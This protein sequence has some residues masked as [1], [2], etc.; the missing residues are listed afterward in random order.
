MEQVIYGDLLFLINFSMDFLTLYLCAH[1]L[2]LAPKARYL[3]IA[4]IV[5]GVYGVIA[6]VLSVGPILSL[7]IHMAVSALMCLV[8]FSP[9]RVSHLVKSMA[10]F[11]GIGF[12]MGGSMTAL[13]HLCNTYLDETRIFY[14]G[15]YETL[16]ENPGFRMV[17]LLAAVSAILVFVVARIFSHQVRR[18]TG[19]LSFSVEGRK[20]TV[21]ALC[22]SGNLLCDSISGTPVAFVQYQ[23]AK[24]IL[25]EQWNRFFSSPTPQALTKLPY[26]YARRVRVLSA[27]G[28]ENGQTM[29]YC[30]RPDW[31]KVDGEEKAMLLAITAPDA[32]DFAGYGAL[33]P[34]LSY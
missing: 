9:R 33:L 20:M 15:N 25:G 29:L 7:L 34:V 1:L 17:L 12:L 31:V 22:D 5:G 21:I 3:G 4:S 11:Y 27:R 2:H 30:L 16:Q 6:V 26:S 19:E 14:A 18:K 32:K 8:A 24:K 10:L 28:I 23:V 13:Y